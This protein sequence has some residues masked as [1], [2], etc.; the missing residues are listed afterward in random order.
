V[1]Q[2]AGQLPLSIGD[3]MQTLTYK[4]ITRHIVRC[5][6]S[7]PCTLVIGPTE[8]LSET[9]EHCSAFNMSAVLASRAAISIGSNYAVIEWRESG[10]VKTSG[11]LN[12]QIARQE[13]E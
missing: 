2:L 4:S 7:E 3:A 10:P 5:F 6:L 12:I 13:S 8:R 11:D 1:E 9:H